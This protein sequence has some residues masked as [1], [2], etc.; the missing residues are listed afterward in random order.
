MGTLSTMRDISAG[1][2]STPKK[3]TTKMPRK[4]HQ[5]AKMPKGWKMEEVVDDKVEEVW[6]RQKKALSDSTTPGRLTRSASRSL[7]DPSPLSPVDSK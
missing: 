7:R 5:Y 2:M 1:T 6:E 3:K 4:Y